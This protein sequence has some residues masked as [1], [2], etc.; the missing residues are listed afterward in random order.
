[1]TTQLE[2]KLNIAKA[3]L[4][5]AGFSLSYKSNTSLSEYYSFPNRTGEIRLSDHKSHRGVGKNNI[6]KKLPRINLTINSTTKSANIPDLVAK[7]IGYFFIR[8]S[9]SS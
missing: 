2:S 4:L 7:A 1:M 9:S 5:Q 8:S 3:N 6:M